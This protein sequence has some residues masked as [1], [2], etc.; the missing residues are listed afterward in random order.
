MDFLSVWHLWVIAGLIAIALEIKLS[1]FVMLWFAV[2]AFVT[3][4]AAALGFGPAVQTL[5]FT[6]VSLSLFAASRTIFQQFFM[7][8]A[9]PMKIGAEAMMGAEATVVDAVPALGS[10]TVR[11]NGELWAARSVDGAIAPGELVEVASI[12]G[13]KLKVRRAQQAPMEIAPSKEKQ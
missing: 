7:R 1:G 2:G 12:D 13:L 5:M 6:L 10:G 4:L 8:N 11:I 9:P 3:A